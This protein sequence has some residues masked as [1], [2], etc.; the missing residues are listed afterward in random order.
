MDRTA[1]ALGLKNAVDLLAANLAQRDALNALKLEGKTLTEITAL[2][3]A[4][5]AANAERL[6]G[7]TYDEIVTILTGDGS[8]VADLQAQLAAFIARRDNPHEVTKDQV[9][10]GLVE[11]FAVATSEE[12]AAGAVDK[13]VTPAIAK[14]LVQ[15]GID[16]LVGTAPEALDTIQEL[17]AALQN[18]PDVINSLLEQIATKETPA[19]AQAKADDALAQAKAYTDAEATETLTAAQ[20]YN[21]ASIQVIVDECNRL[22]AEIEGVPAGV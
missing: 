15:A 3:L 20:A 18:N 21:D 14:E 19:G 16:A 11:N 7:K 10:L 4:G 5:T 12:A 8:L 1:L 9:G 17:A 22:A 6:D 2:I 13:Y